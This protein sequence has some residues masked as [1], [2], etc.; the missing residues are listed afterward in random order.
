MIETEV[1]GE[2]AESAVQEQLA[3]L[4]LRPNIVQVA[5]STEIMRRAGQIRSAARDVGMKLASPDA[6]FV[7]TALLHASDA[8]PHVTL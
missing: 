2:V 7:A 1:I 5:A 3:A 4:F 6:I 8:L